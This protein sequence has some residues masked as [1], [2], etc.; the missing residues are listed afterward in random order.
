MSMTKDKTAENTV[1]SSAASDYNT[2]VEDIVKDDRTIF[3]KGKDAFSGNA[4]RRF[5]NRV[6][7]QFFTYD[8]LIG[9]ETDYKTMFIPS[10]PFT[11]F[12]PRVPHFYGVDDDLPLLLT[13]ILGFQHSLAMIGGLASPSLIFASSAYLNQDDTEYLISCAFIAAGFMTLL[14]ICRFRIPFTNIYM[15]TGMISVL[16]QSFSTV[17]V[18]T[19]TLPKLYSNGFCPTGSDGTKLPCRD[20][21]GAFIGTGALCALLEIL[22]AFIPPRTLKKLFPPLV[23]GPVVLLVGSSLVQSGMQDWGGGSDCYP[24]AL[25]NSAKP[26]HAHVWGSGQ[27]VGLGFSVIVAIMFCDRFGAPIMKSCSI[28]IGLLTGC[29]IAGATGYFQHESID[30]ASSG[31]FNWVRPFPLK[32]YG[33]IVLPILA[34]YIT[35]TVESIG[36]I[37]ASADVSR[38]KTEGEEFES[39]VQ[40]G[41]L[42]SG[43]GSV[44]GNLANVTPLSSFAQNNGVISMTQVASKKAGLACCVWL[45]IYGC[46]GKWTATIAAMPKTIIGGMTT[47]L[48]TSVAV[49]GISII[50]KSSFSRRD[51]VV[52]TITLVFG[53]GSLLVPTWFEGVFT[54]KGDNS[55]KQGFIDAIVLVVQTPYCVAGVV[56]CLANLL[57]PEI[58]E[59]ILDVNAYLGQDPTVPRKPLEGFDDLAPVGTQQNLQRMERL[60]NLHTT[61]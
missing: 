40:G 17:S 18:F 2:S 22:L 30:A 42:A 45:I 57:I 34:V 25:C 46:I 9:N 4:M 3:Q 38:L 39:R 6:H 14:Q 32:L 56:G 15:G 41:V 5:K 8:G 10:I 20:A 31:Q 50:S 51:R 11:R 61:D 58:D 28:V 48:F 24:D 52:L 7:H 53:M 35:C 43:I 60:Q 19:S 47:F 29:I 44:I 26:S 12:K 54:Y 49:S 37:T 59:D 16:G 13:I 23:T 21:Y 27:W 55:G 1:I 36:D 33:P